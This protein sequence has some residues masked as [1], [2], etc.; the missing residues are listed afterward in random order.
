MTT[1][2]K[3]LSHAEVDELIGHAMEDFGRH[4]EAAELAIKPR[5]SVRRTNSL[6]RRAADLAVVAVVDIPALADALTL[7]ADEIDSLHRHMA[8]AIREECRQKR[9]ADTA[10]DDAAWLRNEVTRLNAVIDQLRAELGEKAGA[11]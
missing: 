10:A 8:V 1:A 7:E 6:A 9:R 2:R 4:A 3:I 5:R 11:Q